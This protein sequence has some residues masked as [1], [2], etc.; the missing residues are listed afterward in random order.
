[1]KHVLNSLITSLAVCVAFQS[2]Q[3][4]WL[5]LY[6]G[7]GFLISLAAKR[8]GRGDHL[9]FVVLWPPGLIIILVEDQF[10]KVMSR[11]IPGYIISINKDEE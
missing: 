8:V 4:I 10:V 2:P 7:I 3:I 6:L 9:M 11:I 1:M 5:Y